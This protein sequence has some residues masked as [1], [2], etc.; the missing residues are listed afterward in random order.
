MPIIPIDGS[1]TREGEVV[2]EYTPSLHAQWIV[3]HDCLNF[4]TQ[5]AATLLCLGK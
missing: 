3:L 5:R 1:H 2:K 4:T